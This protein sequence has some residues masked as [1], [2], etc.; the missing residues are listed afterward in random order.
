GGRGKPA[1]AGLQRPRRELVP[2]REHRVPEPPAAR[3]EGTDLRVPR[4]GVRRARARRAHL[5]PDQPEAADLVAAQ[6]R[7]V[8][9][10]VPR[11][12]PGADAGRALCP[13]LRIRPPARWR[14]RTSASPTSSPARRAAPS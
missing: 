8:V 10:V 4:A 14:P 5:R 9:P 12:L 11:V 6:L 1:E 13:G 3:P 2:R 7:V